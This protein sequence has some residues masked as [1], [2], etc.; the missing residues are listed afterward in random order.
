MF[1]SERLFNWARDLRDAHSL[2]LADGAS[3]RLRAASNN[4]QDDDAFQRLFFTLSD[5]T[6]YLYFCAG[7]PANALWAAR[8]GAL[9]HADGARSYVMVAESRGELVGFAR[10]S[11]EPGADPTD[12]S[13]DLGI[14][15]ADGWQGRGLGGH[16]LCRLA[17]EAHTRGVTALTATVLWENRRMLRLAR[18]IFPDTHI[19]Y[20]YGMSELAIDLDLWWDKPDERLCG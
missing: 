17:A 13:A 7:I 20:G 15:L 18:R 4:G 3:V 2:Q 5:T 9:S 6:R 1:K 19:T 16:M 11:Q 12:R 14:L 10:F 8:F